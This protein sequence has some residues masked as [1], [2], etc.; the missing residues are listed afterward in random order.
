V[1]F[2]HEVARIL[3]ACGLGAEIGALS[4]PAP[5][6]E[7]HT[8]DGEVLLRFGGRDLASSGWPDFN[9]FWQPALEARLEAAAIAAGADVRRGVEATAIAAD[10]TTVSAHLRLTP[11]AETARAP[12]TEVL[13]ARYVI[14]CDGSNSTVRQLMGIGMVDLGFFFDWLI[15]DVALHEPRI[16]DPVNL[17]V[18]DPQRPTSVI[19]GGPGRRRWEFM[20]L[21]GERTEDLDREDMA[22]ELLAPWDVTPDNATLERHTVYRFHARWAEQWQRGH[23]LLAGDAAHQMPPFAGQGMCSGLRDAANL[24]WKL[25]AVLDGRAPD[26]LL[27]QYEREREANVRTLIEFSMSLGQVI[28]VT[29]PAE[30]TARDEVMLAARSTPDEITVPPPLPGVTTGV[31]A[32]DDP[33]AG[34]LF[35][36]G[37]LAGDEGPALTDDIVGSGWRLFVRAPDGR[38]ASEPSDPGT[39][40]AIE[41]L[42]ATVVPVDDAADVDGVYRT[43]FDDNGV[44]AVLQRPD[45]YVFGAA[46]SAAEIPALLRAAAAALSAP[47]QNETDTPDDAEPAGSANPL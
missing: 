16:F 42:E 40:A 21:P 6:Y 36:Q 20:A 47:V 22:W 30:A 11:G 32:Q 12:S 38:G 37:R 3:Q 13:D 31:I 44:L 27:R 35:V 2:D 17:Q 4:E 43:Y 25:D 23:V 1:H 41:T 34:T 39:R 19:S 7:W 14:G 9:M 8:A 28:C 29:D 26:S 10:G 18:C 45:F 24:A 15:V 5:T 46:R 33:L